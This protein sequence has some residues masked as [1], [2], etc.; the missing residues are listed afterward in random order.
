MSIMIIFLLTKSKYAKIGLCLILLFLICL[1]I[2]PASHDRLME[3][4]PQFGK[5]G[6]IELWG[7]TITAWQQRPILGFGVSAVHAKAM[8]EHLSY[9]ILA[10]SHPHNLFLTI[11][12]ETG[13]LGLASFIWCVW[14][15]F[16]KLFSL[17]NSYM[18]FGLLTGF[19][20]FFLVNLTDYIFEVRIQAVFWIILGLAFAYAKLNLSAHSGHYQQG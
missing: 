3:L 9:S 12:L 20:S 18:G 11:L 17:R 2:V 19:L 14:R 7:R 6:R 15:I 16:A 5:S 1:L 13:I 8:R 4:Y 10:I